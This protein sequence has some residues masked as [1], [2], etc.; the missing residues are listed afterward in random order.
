MQMLYVLYDARCEL[1]RW[2]K[3]WLLHQ[4]SWLALKMLPAG[5]EQARQMFPGIEEIASSDDLVVISDEGEV[6]LNNHAWIMCLFALRHYRSWS[7]KLSNPLLQPLARQAYVELSK[8]RATISQFMDDRELADRLRVA[9][10][11]SCTRDV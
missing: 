6:Y 2:L 1:C 5:S 9:P 4:K 3:D 8:H 10:A 11:A 7:G